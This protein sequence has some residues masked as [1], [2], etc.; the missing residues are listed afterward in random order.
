[1]AYRAQ[2]KRLLSQ[3]LS[4]IENVR[5]WSLQSSQGPALILIATTWLVSGRLNSYLLIAQIASTTKDQEKHASA[6][7]AHLS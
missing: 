7:V 3:S 6:I 2:N 5:I 4:T 1:L